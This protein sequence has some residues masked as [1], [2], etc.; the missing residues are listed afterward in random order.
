[1]FPAPSGASSGATRAPFSLPVKVFLL[2][3]GSGERDALGTA[4][5]EPSPFVPTPCSARRKSTYPFVS[6]R[7]GLRLPTCGCPRDG[8]TGGPWPAT[9]A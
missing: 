7:K 9:C 1:M 5:I 8:A 6:S 4:G 2:E 3:Y